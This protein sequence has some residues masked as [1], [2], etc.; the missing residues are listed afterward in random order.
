MFN[1]KMRMKEKLTAE[2]NE[3][4]LKLDRAHKLTDGLS[5]EKE[6]WAQDIKK[7]I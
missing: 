3:C 6:R 5:E 4:Q 7:L 2:I 1:E